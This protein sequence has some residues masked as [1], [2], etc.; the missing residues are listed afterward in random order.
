MTRFIIFVDGSNLTGSLKYL[1]LRVKEYGTF[2]NYILKQAIDSWSSSVMGG[3]YGQARLIRVLWYAVGSID[4]WKLDEPE[5]KNQ[6]LDW[7]KSDKDLQ[8]KYLALAGSNLSSTEASPIELASEAW[9]LCFSEISTWYNQKKKYVD[10]LRDF[11]FGVSSGTDFIDIIACGHLKVDILN[12][13]L[14][15]KGIDTSLAVDMVTLADIY[16]VALIISGDADSIPSIQR[17]KHKGKQAGVIEFIKGYPPEK[18]GR[19]S[20][21]KLK[22]AAD[23]IVPIYESELQQKGIAT[24]RNSDS[25]T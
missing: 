25:F 15:E 1:N 3:G 11:H 17:I 20:S 8:R 2:L 6:L 10:G 23:F 16:D 7:F 18:R 9:R 21:S 13:N 12:K 19:Q 24:K 5:S 22:A 4:I 14:Y